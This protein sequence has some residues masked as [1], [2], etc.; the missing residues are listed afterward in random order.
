[1]GGEG[2][3]EGRVVKLLAPMIQGADMRA[4]CVITTVA[5]PSS[6]LVTPPFQSRGFSAPTSW[7]LTDVPP[8]LMRQR[9]VCMVYSTCAIIGVIFSCCIKEY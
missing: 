3:G 4:F 1:M 9:C 7:A 2:G 6:I 8:L 5:P